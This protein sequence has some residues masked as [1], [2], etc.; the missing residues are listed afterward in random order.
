MTIDTSDMNRVQKSVLKDAL[1]SYADYCVVCYGKAKHT[2]PDLANMW[3][4]RGT[5]ADDM[6]KDIIL[7]FE[8]LFPRPNERV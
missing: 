8:Q 4:A 1:V 3:S 6:S 7:A 5:C 2:N